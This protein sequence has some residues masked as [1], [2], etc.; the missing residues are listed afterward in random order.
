[1]SRS[2]IFKKIKQAT[3]SLTETTALPDYDPTLL[4]AP[5]KLEGDSLLEIFRRNFTAVS[6]K[7]MDSVEPLI[8]F[9]KE[10]DQL[11]GFCDPALMETVGNKLV[12]AGLTVETEYDRSRYD[13]YTFGITRATG[14][15]AE[16]GTL[17]LNDEQT[18]DRL[19]ALSPWVHVAVLQPSEIIKTIPEAI[20]SF[21]TSPNIIWATGP[22][23][24][25]DVEGI[26]IEGVHGPG[27]EIALFCEI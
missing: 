27:E 14:A 8:T 24:T 23:K 5:K 26:L 9:L 22:S 15:I 12:E 4:H 21:G 3:D 13:D 18:A 10:N 25:A 1:M 16:S 20:D 11:H 2:D 6:G 7:V 19:A 17:I